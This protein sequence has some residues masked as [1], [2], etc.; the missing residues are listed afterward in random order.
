MGSGHILVYA[1]DVFM[2]IYKSCGY[3][4]SDAAISIAENN[5]FGLDIDDRAYQL[6]YFAVMMKGRQYDGQ[7]LNKNMKLNICAI[8]DTKNLVRDC[9][10]L[11]GKL[12]SVANRLADEFID[13]KEY[14]SILNL[15]ITSDDLV[16]LSNKTKVICNTEYNNFFDTARAAGVRTD[17]VPLVRQAEMMTH[18]YDVVVTNPP[19]MGGTMNAKLSTFIKTRYPDTKSD[20][21]AV[22]IEKCR[23]LTINN[24]FQA[25]VVPESWMFLS[26]YNNLRKNIFSSMTC[27]NTCHLGT[28]AFDCGF[29]TVAFSYSKVRIDNYRSKYVKLNQFQSTEEKKENIKNDNLTYLCGFELFK[30]LPNEIMAYWCSEQ[31]ADTLY[32]A[33]PFSDFYKLDC[34]IKTGNNE[35][36]LRLW[37]EVS[38]VKFCQHPTV[39]SL[40]R[41][42]LKWFKYNKGG[43]YQRWYGGYEYVVNFHNDAS[44]IKSTVNKDTYRLRNS[45]NYFVKGIIWPLIGDVRFSSRYLPEDL[46]ID[47]ASNGIYFTN[48]YDY[49]AIAFMNS[50]VFN[51]ILNMIN[52]TVSYPIDS[53]AKVPYVPALDS[54]IPEKAKQN[55]TLAK[56]DWDSFETSW[57]FVKHPLIHS[58]STTI[59]AFSSWKTESNNRFNVLKTNE[60]LLN[61]IFI[62][63]Y[64]LQDE[65][66]PEVDDKDVKIRKADLGRDIRSFLSF[67]IGCMFGR[68]SLDI[69]GLAYAGGEWDNDK[70]KTYIPDADNCIPI[71]D[72]DYFTDDIVGRFTEF[73]KTVYGSDTLEENLDF[74]ANAL[75]NTGNTSRE[76][77]RN[78][79]IKDFYKDH[80]KIYQKRPI[81]WLFDSG[82][83]NGFK[84][85]IYMHRYNADTIGNMRIEYLHRMQR[86]YENEMIRMQEVIDNSANTRDIATAQKRKDKMTKQLKETRDYDVKIAHLALARIE[87]DLDD[88]VKVNYEKVQTDTNGKVLDVLAEV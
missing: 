34:G 63:I 3:T 19:Y 42:D 68:Y 1:F 40:K 73:V 87:I 49:R 76:I 18:L 44:E 2:Q 69:D 38:S 22:F 6:A 88:G 58:T 80:C 61:S 16:L 48:E 85:L 46:L 14:G 71:T 12:E 78:Y 54:T 60:E 72:E 9:L 35:K 26:T 10:K 59:K 37:H 75:R 20:L 25:M 21:F 70:Y 28:K 66:T 39:D 50:S 27:T 24:G 52:P 29:G 8:N 45:E 47:V 64:G 53:I 33:A 65:L 79:F 83:E 74:I 81:Y 4:Q 30:K 15:N 11:F 57:D 62:D 36:F 55:I 5:I 84:A 17:F 43:G 31:F 86:V 56:A 7:F 51:T 67:A 23:S 32:S 41:I 82:K 13:A 77:I